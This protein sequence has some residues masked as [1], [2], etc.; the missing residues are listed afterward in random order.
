MPS[1]LRTRA[2]ADTSV[3]C[4]ICND[5]RTTV[6]GGHPG[7]VNDVREIFGVTAECPI[8][9]DVCSTLMALPC[10]HILCKD[11][12]QR[13]SRIRPASFASST[14]PDFRNNLHR[15]D[16]FIPNNVDVRRTAHSTATIARLSESEA[17]RSTSSTRHVASQS[18]RGVGGTREATHASAAVPALSIRSETYRSATGAGRNN[19]PT[20]PPTFNEATTA[21]VVMV[22]PVTVIP[23]RA[24]VRS[25]I[26]AVAYGIVYF[27]VGDTLWHNVPKHLRE[28]YQNPIIPFARCF[29]FCC[30]CIFVLL[31]L[32][33]GQKPRSVLK[34]PLAMVCIP[35][36]YSI[37]IFAVIDIVV[38]L[39]FDILLELRLIWVFGSLTLITAFAGLGRWFVC[40][41]LLGKLEFFFLLY[42][43]LVCHSTIFDEVNQLSY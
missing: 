25:V 12:Y 29:V 38:R 34:I 26:G 33:K 40:D 31:E 41:A 8:C 24:T 43:V 36:I 9:L 20:M 2:S 18:A 17:S 7:Q 16:V 10:G 37:W 30:F 11:D 28:S 32:P 22:P 5:F 14:R 4:P 6:V 42:G 15:S 27:I 21:N 19:D 35:F 39:K 1:T 13:M 3:K 23:E